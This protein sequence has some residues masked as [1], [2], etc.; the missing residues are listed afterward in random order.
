MDLKRRWGPNADRDGG[1]RL[2]SALASVRGSDL[3]AAV[4]ERQAKAMRGGIASLALQSVAPE[5]AVPLRRVGRDG[6]QPE[7]AVPDRPR[8][9]DPAPKSRRLYSDRR[10]HSISGWIGY[11]PE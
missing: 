7:Q 5:V 11:G 4:L 6:R 8:P 1:Q 3:V 9:A 2:A 10:G